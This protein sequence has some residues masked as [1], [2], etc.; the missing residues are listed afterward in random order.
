MFNHMDGSSCSF[1]AF[2][3]DYSGPATIV[4][5]GSGR[6]N[7]QC[8]AS[9]VSGSAVDSATR[10]TDIPVGTIFG[11][12]FCDVQYTRSGKANVSCHN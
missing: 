10:Q 4:Q 12:V 3:G 8:N 9:L 5:S 6:V 11:L 1:S 2:G 7:A